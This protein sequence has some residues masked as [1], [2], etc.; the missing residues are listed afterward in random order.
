MENHGLN[1][2]D[3]QGMDRAWTIMDDG[4]CCPYLSMPCPS[5]PLS[6]WLQH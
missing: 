3:G 2:R 5:R 4:N 1:G 6:P